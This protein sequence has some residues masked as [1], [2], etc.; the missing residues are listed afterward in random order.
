MDPDPDPARSPPVRRESHSFCSVAIVSHPSSLQGPGPASPVFCWPP[1][2]GSAATLPGLGGGG[3]R[4]MHV[5]RPPQDACQPGVG[6]PTRALWAARKVGE[7]GTKR[8]YYSEHPSGGPPSLG[9]EVVSFA[10]LVQ[11]TTTLPEKVFGEHASGHFGG[12]IQDDIFSPRCSAMGF[13][14]KK[15]TCDLISR[16]SRG[17]GRRQGTVLLCP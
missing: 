6:A 3:C 16:R 9:A 7:L 2:T 13:V 12:N 10:E 8:K 5:G 14:K 1:G 11:R 15:S 17:T 4:D